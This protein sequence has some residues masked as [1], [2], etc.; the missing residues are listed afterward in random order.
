[1]SRLPTGFSLLL[2]EMHYF[3]LLYSKSC[4]LCDL[5]TSHVT[6]SL[7]ITF[8][9]CFIGWWVQPILPPPPPLAP[10][11]FA[12][13]CPPNKVNLGDISKVVICASSIPHLFPKNNFHTMFFREMCT[14]LPILTP[15]FCTNMPPNQSNFWWYIQMCRL[16]IFSTSHVTYFDLIL[17]IYEIIDVF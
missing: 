17:L 11:F 14:F 8:I 10:P 12:P 2:P 1:M 6:Y 13:I 15:R 16:H 9:L 5:S 7:K 4:H 3:T